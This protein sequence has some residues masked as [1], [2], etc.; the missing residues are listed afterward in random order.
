MMKTELK[1]FISNTYNL[2]DY[3]DSVSGRRSLYDQ[4]F[5]AI[6]FVAQIANDKTLEKEL[7]DMWYNEWKEKLEEKVYG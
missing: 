5:G 2:M 4:C 7:E 3:L 6:S 1:K